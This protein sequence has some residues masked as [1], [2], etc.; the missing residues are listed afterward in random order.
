[1]EPKAIA[2]DRNNLAP[3]LGVA[4]Q[5]GFLKDAVLRMGAG[6][7]YSQYPWLAAQMPLI[8]SPPFVSGRPFSNSQTTPYPEYVLGRNVFPENTPAVVTAGYAASLPNGTVASGLDP[9]M[10]TSYA[11]QW[12]LSIQKAIG[13]NNSVEWNY[14]GSSGSR[15]LYYTDLSQCRPA[16]DLFCT[17]AA[18]PWPRYDL[19]AWF[20]S[21]GNSSWQGMVA[22]YDHRT[23]GGLNF[24]LEY[25]FSKA[26]T[27]A[28][29]S[30]QRSTNQISVCRRCDKGPAAFDVRHRGVASVV[31]EAP[32]GRGRRFGSA[33]PAAGE[34]LAGNWTVTAIAT[35]STGQPVVLSSP[36]QTR[37][38]LNVAVPNR[39]CDGRSDALS[40]NVRNNGFLWFDASCFPIPSVGYFGNSGR[41]VLSGP[42]LHNWDLGVEK[43]FPLHGEVT[44]LNFRL[45]AFNVWNHAQFRQ[46][47][48]DAG[49]G[50]NF[51][52]IAATRTPRVLQLALKL[53]W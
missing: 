16:A 25:T 35:F 6:I 19:I 43:S 15:L 11:S 49:A 50:T 38:L 1:M 53:Y 41:T 42:G 23:L 30:S 24:R 8:L 31:W 4:W 37:D 5:P 26:L 51:G 46:P 3:R 45:E 7:Y 9:A 17:P 33:L 13:A 2:T 28:W 12:T 20:E 32:V 14:I 36:S 21:T 18:K 39:I 44:R 22:K 40:G 52:R 47:N 34:L 10:R 48:G 29:Q 27:D